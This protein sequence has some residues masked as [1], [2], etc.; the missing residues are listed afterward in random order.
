MRDLFYIAI[1]LLKFH[2]YNV[3]P[4][5]DHKYTSRWMLH[6]FACTINTLCNQIRGLAPTRHTK[7]KKTTEI[8]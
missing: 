2:L 6:I 4:D 5:D 3:C 1:V 8:K 7:K